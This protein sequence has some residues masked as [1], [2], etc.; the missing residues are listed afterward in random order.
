MAWRRSAA[1]ALTG[2]KSIEAPRPYVLGCKWSK[3]VRQFAQVGP[4]DNQKEP[5]QQI[6]AKKAG[7]RHEERQPY[8]ALV[9][10][11]RGVAPSYCACNVTS[12]F[13]AGAVS[14]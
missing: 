13:R 10:R 4:L 5:M 1:P 2:I 9:R 11:A 6:N 14:R 8:G 12:G 3:A 7:M